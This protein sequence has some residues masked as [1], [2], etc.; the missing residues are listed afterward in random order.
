MTT[1]NKIS[2]Q[3]ERL[4][5]R[6]FDREDLKSRIER[7]EIE[8]LVDQA[9]NTLLSIEPQQQARV[10]V[11]DIPSCMIATY[12]DQKVNETNGVYWSNLPAFPVRLPM[13]M[14]VWSISPEIGQSFIPVRSD[15]MDLLAAED[16]GALE[17]QVGFVVEGRR[18]TFTENPGATV[19]MKL[20]IVDPSRLDKYDPYPVSAEMEK[21]I[22]DMVLETLSARGLAPEKPKG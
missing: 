5:M 9:A 19:K 13:D 10:G 6:P 20:L 17:G 14:G 22:I 21:L 12:H 7:R 1:R 2:E 18:V 11:V 8:L 15:L 3:I 16:E 4:Y